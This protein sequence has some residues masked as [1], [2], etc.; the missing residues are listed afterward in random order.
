M[1]APEKQKKQL[2]TAKWG[3][4][5]QKGPSILFVSIMAGTACKTPGHDLKVINTKRHKQA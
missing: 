3:P 5:R 2:T 4:R 1:C